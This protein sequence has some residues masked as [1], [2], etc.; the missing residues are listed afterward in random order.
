MLDT[1]WQSRRLYHGLCASPIDDPFI[2]T[3]SEHYRK[4]GNDENIDFESMELWIGCMETQPL[5]VGFQLKFSFMCNLFSKA[6]HPDDHAI[7]SHVLIEE[8]KKTVFDLI[9]QVPVRPPKAF[10]AAC[11]YYELAERLIA[12]GWLSEALVYSI[13]AQA[14]RQFVS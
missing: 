12:N 13:G 8:V 2:K 1:L 14:L 3:F 11:L 4:E 6:S 9:S 5:K 10:I 7:I